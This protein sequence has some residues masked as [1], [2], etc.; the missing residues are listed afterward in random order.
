MP[1]GSSQWVTS[2]SGLFDFCP[3]TIQTLIQSPASSL[4]ALGAL[5]VPKL[6]P[7]TDTDI[8]DRHMG[9]SMPTEFPPV[10]P[11]Q[12]IFLSV[13][14]TV[15]PLV[16]HEK[17]LPLHPLSSP[18]EPTSP[19]F[20]WPSRVCAYLFSLPYLLDKEQVPHS[21]FNCHINIH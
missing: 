16:F 10:H 12:H 4:V 1:S 17:S 14:V 8:W 9:V 15:D 11:N 7:N 18:E 5:R 2:W 6:L 3:L 20:W 13:S 21:V 19:A